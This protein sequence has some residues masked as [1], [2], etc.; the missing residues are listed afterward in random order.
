MVFDALMFFEDLSKTGKYKQE[1]HN[2]LKSHKKV[3]SAA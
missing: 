3:I 2:S 1:L